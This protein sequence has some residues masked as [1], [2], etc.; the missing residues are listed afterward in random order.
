METPVHLRNGA[1][2]G[3]GLGL[4]I[5]N[6]AGPDGSTHTL[7]HHAGEISGFRAHNYL[8]PETGT[9]VVILTNAEYSEATT[10]LAKRLAIVLSVAPDP[11]PHAAENPQEARARALLTQLAQGRIDRTQLTPEAA[12]V[13]TS[14]ALRDIEQSLQPLGNL[15]RVTLDSASLRGGTT[16]LALTAKFQWR[17]LQIAEYDLPNGTIQQFMIDDTAQ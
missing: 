3:Y 4:F 12:T 7:L 5:E 6:A 8:V 14:Q 11:T 13:F 17:T 2:T 15:E 16:H 9:A 1:S 10:D